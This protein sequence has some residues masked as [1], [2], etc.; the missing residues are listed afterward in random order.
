MNINI[1]LI[2]VLCILFLFQCAS[3]KYIEETYSR[4]DGIILA[5]KKSIESYKFDRYT[6]NDIRVNENYITVNVSFSGGCRN[7]VFNLIAKEYF[8]DSSRPEVK[9]VLSHDSNFDPCESY[10]TED[11]IFSVLPLKYAFIKSFEK[12]S[13]S[14]LLILEENELVYNF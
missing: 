12:E 9:L 3:Q 11:H 2:L 7:H 6:L 4:E 13:G 8:G 10:V 1:K 5:N 14:I